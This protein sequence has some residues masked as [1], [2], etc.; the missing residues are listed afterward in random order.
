MRTGA[1]AAAY[2]RCG[3]ALLMRQARLGHFHADTLKVELN[4]GY[5]ALRLGQLERAETT[6]RRVLA[7]LEANPSIGEAHPRVADAHLR[8]GECLRKQGN[9]DGAATAF[10]RC[11][12]LRRAKLGDGSA[13]L[14]A[15]L[16]GLGE[17]L[18]MAGDGAAADAAY[19]RARAALRASVGDDHI[20]GVP[21][22][23]NLGERA[24][25]AGDAPRAET[26]LQ[27]ALA[28][29]TAALGANS[30]GAARLETQLALVH[31]AR[32]EW[33]A[34]EQRLETALTTRAALH[35]DGHPDLCKPLLHLAAV[36]QGALDAG[37]HPAGRFK[38]CGRIVSCHRRALAIRQ[39]AFG[40][41]HA[42]TAEVHLAAAAFARWR[43]Q[44]GQAERAQRRGLEVLRAVWPPH[45]PSVEAAI[46]SLA[47]W[48]AEDARPLPLA[49]LL[50][51]HCEALEGAMGTG[52]GAASAVEAEVDGGE[53]G[54]ADAAVAH[55]DERRHPAA[56]ARERW[57]SEYVALLLALGKGRAA[58]AACE[59]EL[60]SEEER[61]AALGRVSAEGRA[62]T[63][64]RAAA[65]ASV[66][67][68][69]LFLD[70]TTEGARS[71]AACPSEVPAVQRAAR[72]LASVYHSLGG[73]SRERALADL[74][75]R[76]RLP[77]PPPSTDE[78]FEALLPRQL[79]E[80]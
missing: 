58:A 75:S 39:V 21:L 6:L 1:W 78:A 23:T 67:D 14:I 47:S 57:F 61:A 27:H 74:S 31:R 55:G 45:H 36:L 41:E 70:L 53:E 37:A 52:E 28:V 43:G 30:D 72:Q 15:P 3:R 4:V 17:T 29:Q 11:A 59:R 13:G 7:S 12:E 10:R 80:D 56:A 2:E 64:R 5:C 44:C 25:S 79:R 9:V 65:A 16:T 8:L 40:D 48:L 24:L 19:E 33:S 71:P 68:G 62:S 42:K 66:D 54:V 50:R 69:A 46:S 76:F 38:L 51:G 77:L 18:E 32:G 26:H 49:K 34:A 73:R 60:W 35:G 20:D 22:F 63:E